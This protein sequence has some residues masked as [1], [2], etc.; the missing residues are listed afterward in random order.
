[1]PVFSHR[2]EDYRSFNMYTS[3]LVVLAQ[4]SHFA[5]EISDGEE[6]YFA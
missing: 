5:E 4:V 6:K 2:E 3:Q 1:M